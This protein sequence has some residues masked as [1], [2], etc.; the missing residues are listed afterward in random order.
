[1]PGTGG[2]GSTG[3]IFSSETLVELDGKVGAVR[4]FSRAS[5]FR[6]GRGPD[7]TWDGGWVAEPPDARITLRQG[8]DWQTPIP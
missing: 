8:T 2:K 5:A 3:P 1:M 4:A 6:T 7:P